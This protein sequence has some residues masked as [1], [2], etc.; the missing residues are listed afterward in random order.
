LPNHRSDSTSAHLRSLDVFT[1]K[2]VKK[3]NTMTRPEAK[4][5]R[6]RES[7][8]NKLLLGSEGDKS[9][10]PNIRSERIARNKL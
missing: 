10:P 3:T 2:N 1:D 5:R 6:G 9:I 4:T 7:P 8:R